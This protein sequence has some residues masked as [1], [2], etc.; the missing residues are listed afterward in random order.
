MQGRDRFV[1]ELID[2]GYEPTV[3]DPNLVSFPYLIQN[4]PRA[5]ELVEL[6]VEVPVNFPIESPHG[7]CYKPAILRESAVTGVHPGRHFGPEWDH[8]SRPHPRWSSTDRSVR[9][10][11]R[12]VRSLNEELP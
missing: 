6:G 7:P 8:W 11:L 12:H 5:G 2:L 9:A 1:A 4:G 3:R 10:Y